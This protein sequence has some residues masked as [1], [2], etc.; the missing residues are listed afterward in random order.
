MSEPKTSEA[1]THDDEI[2]LAL[3][4]MAEQPERDWEAGQE[5]LQ[6]QRRQ[7]GTQQ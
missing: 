2:D 6:N 4:I 5:W 1:L 3:R 7:W